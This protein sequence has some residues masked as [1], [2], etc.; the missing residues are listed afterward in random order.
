MSTAKKVLCCVLCLLLD[1]LCLMAN[2]FQI[3]TKGF[4]LLL[5]SNYLIW[6]AISRAGRR[7]RKSK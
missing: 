1:G 4:L 5:V 6:L 3:D 2:G 7:R